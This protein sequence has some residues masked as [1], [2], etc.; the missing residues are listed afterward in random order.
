MIPSTLIVNVGGKI[1]FTSHIIGTFLKTP[2]T[3]IMEFA[4]GET[5]KK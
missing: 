5:Q 2:I 1:N 4:D 3:Q